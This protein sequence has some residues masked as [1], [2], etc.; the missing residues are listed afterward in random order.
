MD[1]INCYF[2]KFCN[3]NESFKRR[4]NPLAI[5]Y[6]KLNETYDYISRLPEY[7]KLEVMK[8][9]RMV[10]RRPGKKLQE[11]KDIRFLF[12]IFECPFL[13]HN[14]TED[15]QKRNHEILRRLF[16]II[17]CFS[18]PLLKYIV[19]EFTKFTEESFNK[20]IEIVNYFISYRL[21]N[22][23]DMDIIYPKDWE[24]KAAVKFMSLLYAANDFR[25]PSLPISEFYNMAIDLKIDMNRD[26]INW[27]NNQFKGFVFCHYPFIVSLGQKTKI[28]RM[29]SRQYN[30]QT[31]LQNNIASTS[32]NVPLDIHFNINVRRDHLIQDSIDQIQKALKDNIDMKK[33]LKV[34][35]IGEDGVDAG[36]LRK[37]WLFLLVKKLFDPN[38]GMFKFDEG[39]H[40]CWFSPASFENEN[41]YKLLG[42]IIG[43]AMYNGIILDIHLPLACY[44][45]LKD[46]HCTLEDLREIH[47]QLVQGFDQMLAY[48]GDDMEEVFGMNFVVTYSAFDRVVE[49]PLIENGEN[50][51]INKTNRKDYVERYLHWFFIESVE[52]QYEAF[53]EG[54][55]HFC[56]KNF[57]SICTPEEIQKII[58]GEEDID[59]ESLKNVTT[60]KGC[61][62]NTQVVKWFWEVVGQYDTQMKKKLMIF[63]T[64]SDRI[65]PTGIDDMTFKIS[66]FENS[67]SNDHLPQTHT[68]FNEILL[69]NYD[70]KEIL[71]EK[72]KQAMLYSE[73]FGIR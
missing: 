56:P 18:K 54:F 69:F 30:I 15:E 11:I 4:D 3:L 7:V 13:F 24:I 35:F 71:E 1:H 33:L 17:S 39:T 41:Q 60:Y 14:N 21:T 9:L 52:K 50:I 62:Q 44:K 23:N 5:D 73:G 51:L 12:I 58:L 49:V 8:S 2:S 25:N 42:I 28:L 22:I 43:L 16:G 27:Q 6:D 46:K 72:L 47:P 57:L 34:T 66:Y 61:D 36:G 45:R 38:Y 67:L 53:K 29:E 20:K 26:Y 37:E 68:C 70:S 55:I 10:L 31:I 48:E 63:V 19:D 32:R 65:C 40:L 59:I 64:G